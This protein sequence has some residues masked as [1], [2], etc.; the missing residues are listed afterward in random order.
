MKLPILF[1]RT[2]TTAIQYWEIEVT[3]QEDSGV[4]T[5]TSGQ[6]GTNNP[7]ENIEVVSE[8]KNLGR[9]NQ[10][11]PLEQAT[12]QATSDWKKKQDDGLPRFPVGISFRD[13]E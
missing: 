11:S 6:Y 1:K 3:S 2:R 8:G 4:I 12:S 13:Y 9:A 10:T 7:L 5:K